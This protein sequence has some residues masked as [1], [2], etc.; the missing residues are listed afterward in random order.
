MRAYSNYYSNYYYTLLRAMLAIAFEVI[1]QKIF[2]LFR[3]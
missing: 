2:E 3:A 1:L